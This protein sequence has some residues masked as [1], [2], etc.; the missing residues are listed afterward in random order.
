MTRQV[1]SLILNPSYLSEFCYIWEFIQVKFF[2]TTLLS[3]HFFIFIVKFEK[4]NIFKV[5]KKKDISLCLATVVDSE[6]SFRGFEK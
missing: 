2:L 5:E 1:L 3:G 4:K 6:F